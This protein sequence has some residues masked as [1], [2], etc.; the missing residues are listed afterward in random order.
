MIGDTTNDWGHY[1]GDAVLFAHFLRMQ[2][3]VRAL[4]MR[5]EMKACVRY[6]AFLTVVFTVVLAFVS[7]LAAQ[8]NPKPATDAAQQWLS[9]VDAGHY[10]E[11]WD[12]AAAFFQQ[13]VSKQDWEQM[14]EKTRAP[15]GKVQSRTFKSANYETKLPNAPA[16]KYM[17]VQFR[18][19]FANSPAAIETVTPM[20]GSD[21]QWKVSGYFIRPAD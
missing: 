3:E 17:V 5:W 14:L 13:K 20:L 21:N 10:A 2:W 7:G 6:F 18:T 8:D 15:L 11:S 16:G 19:K 12:H 1:N 4:R 9:Q